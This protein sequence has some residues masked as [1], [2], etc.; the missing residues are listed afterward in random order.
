MILTTDGHTMFSTL[1]VQVISGLVCPLRVTS[2]IVL[3]TAESYS[4]PETHH[5]APHFL[6]TQESECKGKQRERKEKDTVKENL[7]MEQDKDPHL[8]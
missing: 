6:H 7:K 1:N 3:P 2:L 8:R 4:F 5:K